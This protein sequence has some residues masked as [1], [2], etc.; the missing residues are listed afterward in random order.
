MKILVLRFSSIGDI[1]LT[2]PVLRCLKTQLPLSDIHYLTKPAFEPI[3]AASPYIDRI[4]LLD[5]APGS[6]IRMLREEGYDQV[7]DLHHNVRTLRIVNALKAPA[8]SFSKLNAEKWLMV[9]F[10]WN[11]LPDTSIV[12]R[13]MAAVAHLGVINDGLGLDYFISPGDQVDEAS[14]PPAHR[15]GYIALVIGAAHYTKKMPREKLRELCGKLPGP[16]LLLGGPED[17]T[18]GEF[19]SSPDPV[20]IFN[21]CGK[22]RIN[23]SADL[24]KRSMLVVSHDTGLMH[25]AAAFKKQVISI[26]GNTIPEFGMFPYYGRNTITRADPRFSI[27]ENRHLNC[28]PCSKIGYSQCPKTH[29]RCMNDIDL[30][31]VAE[32]ALLRLSRL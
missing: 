6:Q 4:L 30:D 10:K 13:Y 8:H 27:F 29:F 12:D 22:F 26:W 18:S 7:I 28:R 9:N 11:M 3:L 20:R 2:S 31:K 23:Q 14:L 24:I 15:D 21:G 25:I 5:D 1:V 19:I 16:I 17:R 32:N